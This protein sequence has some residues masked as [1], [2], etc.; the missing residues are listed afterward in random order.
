MGGGRGWWLFLG[1]FCLLGS[2]LVCP[3]CSCALGFFVSGSLYTVLWRCFVSGHVVLRVMVM[4]GKEERKK[5]ARSLL[6][7]LLFVDYVVIYFA[8]WFNYLLFVFNQ[9]KPS[10]YLR[11]HP[12][13]SWGSFS[14]CFPF[15]ILFLFIQFIFI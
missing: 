15:L 7:V 11:C 14:S 6:M 2:L 8:W 5:K 1:G 13:S 9:K 3:G 10:C 4:S 12:Y